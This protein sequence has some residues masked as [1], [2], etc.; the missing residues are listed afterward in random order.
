MHHPHAGLN[1]KTG[2]GISKMTSLI[3]LSV[4]SPHTR[5]SIMLNP[6]SHT[7]DLSI[8]SPMLTQIRRKAHL[9]QNWNLDQSQDVR[10]PIRIMVNF[11]VSIAHTNIRYKPYDESNSKRYPIP[12]SMYVQHLYLP[13]LMIIQQQS[14]KDCILKQHRLQLNL[15]HLPCNGKNLA[16]TGNCPSIATSTTN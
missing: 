5:L 9:V 11:S 16:V 12:L 1:P 2:A 4:E 6:A 8:P 15:Q 13:I 14:C 10:L 3:R 7:I